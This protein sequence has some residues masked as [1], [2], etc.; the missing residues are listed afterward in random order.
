M[1]P[2]YLGK[3]ATFRFVTDANEDNPQ[4]FVWQRRKH[5]IRIDG[6]THSVPCLT[7]YNEP[8]P[9]CIKS[10]ELY[11][12][13]DSK[14][15]Q[16]LFRKS[17][18]IAPVLV[19][20]SVDF[21]EYNNTLQCAVIGKHMFTAMWE[22]VEGY[23]DPETEEWVEGLDE[24]PCDSERGM[25]FHYL[26]E[27]HHLVA[28]G[29]TQKETPLTDEEIELIKANPIRLIDHEYE[30]PTQQQIDDWLLL[31]DYTS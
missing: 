8:C 5:S 27:N 1:E 13:G 18:Y 26:I 24:L 4:L 25:D 19:R 9:I 10:A 15:G 20:E 3:S 2:T 11:R 30:K 28:C 7:A 29:F 31:V 12:S 17:H 22:Q 6:H 16:K 23:L 21:P 14:T